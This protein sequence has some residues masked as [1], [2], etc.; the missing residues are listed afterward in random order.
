MLPR[1]LGCASNFTGG[2]AREQ[3]ISRSEVHWLAS[4]RAKARPS[5]GQGQEDVFTNLLCPLPLPT[6][7][8]HWLNPEQ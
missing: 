1:A 6:S 4:Q 7:C 3:V 8:L 2:L 5:A